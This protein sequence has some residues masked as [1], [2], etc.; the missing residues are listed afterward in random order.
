MATR[1]NTVNLRI[2]ANSSTIYEGLITSGPRNITAVSGNLLT[3]FCDGRTPNSPSLPPIN[4]PTAALDEASKRHGFTYEADFFDEGLYDFVIPQIGPSRNYY[5]HE[6]DNNYVQEW[7]N[8]VNYQEASTNEYD[9]FLGGCHER[10]A[11]G[12]EGNVC[13]VF[14]RFVS[15]SYG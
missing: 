3:Y 14:S 15:C 8:L 10:L 2:E 5:D 7:V 12:D 13:D 6:I 1:Y 11:P 4:T 9:W